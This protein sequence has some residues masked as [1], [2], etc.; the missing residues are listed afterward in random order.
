M[1]YFGALELPGGQVVPVTSMSQEF[2]R[3]DF[4]AF[5]PKEVSSI[6]SRR[7]FQ[8][9]FSPRDKKYYLEDLGS[10]NGTMLNGTDVKGRGKVP[11]KD[12][13]VIS[14][15]DVLNLKFKG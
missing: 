14:P 10:T 12:G 3:G 11:I 2:G 7:H 9:S 8:I 13:D 1:Q 15:S 6:I 4:E 5:T